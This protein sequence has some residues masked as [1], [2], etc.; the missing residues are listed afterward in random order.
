MG[1]SGGGFDD[2]PPVPELTPEQKEALV[3]KERGTMALTSGDNQTAADIFQKA[4]YKTPGDP[5]LTGLLQQ[6]EGKMAAVREQYRQAAQKWRVLD[7]SGRMGQGSPPPVA[8][9]PRPAALPVNNAPGGISDH[10]SASVDPAP[11]TADRAGRD[12]FG[13]PANPTNP[14]LGGPKAAARPVDG[15]LNQLRGSAASGKAG[16][17]AGKA[18]DARDQAGC[19]FGAAGCAKPADMPTVAAVRAGTSASAPAEPTA[20]VSKALASDPRY[21][22][23]AADREKAQSTAN[24]KQQE[25]DQLRSQQAATKDPGQ[26][27]AIQIK[28]SDAD[29]EMQTAKGQVRVDEIKQADVKKEV[30]TIEIVPAGGAAKGSQGGQTSQGAQAAAAPTGA[31]GGSSQ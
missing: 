16:A 13:K 25:I 21:Q 22:A 18:E 29:R 4:L 11:W 30:E 20:P 9:R 10:D 27:A 7:A 14:D 24:A 26:Q 12:L 6:A 5:E 28:I 3:L 19:Q 1:F 23:L 2:S 8:N 31:G 17:T 15:A